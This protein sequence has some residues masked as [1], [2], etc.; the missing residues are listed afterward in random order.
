[1][2]RG[3]GTDAAGGGAE[4]GS[5]P[6]WDLRDLYPGRDSPELARDLERAARDADAF[7][8]AYRGKLPGLTGAELGAAV[9]AY[10]RLQETLERI[11]SYA[12]LVYSGNVSDPEIGRFYQLMQ[13]KTNDVSSTL[14]F[15][16]LEINKLEDADLAEKL[17]APAL[18][19]YRS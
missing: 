18:A 17:K 11:M 5:V 6:E 10:E 8:D 7:A 4:F 13:E 19:H 2:A 12:S 15:F 14:L 16:T 9:A 1:M 3:I